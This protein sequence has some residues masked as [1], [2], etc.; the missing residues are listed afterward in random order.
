[1]NMDYT[2]CQALQ[3]INVG[4]SGTVIEYY[5][6]NCQHSKKFRIRVDK[7]SYLSIP[8]HIKLVPGIGLLH[9]TEHKPECVPRYAPTFIQGAGLVA[10]EIIELLWS[11]LNGCASSMRTATKANRAET[12]DDHMNDSNWSKM[13]NVPETIC[14]AY[15]RAATGLPGYQAELEE[16]TAIAGPENV[17]RWGRE[18]A[19][20]QAG[21]DKNI[22]G[23]DVYLA[24]AQKGVYGV[25]LHPPVYSHHLSSHPIRD[26][27]KSTS[28]GAVK[29]RE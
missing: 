3:H 4:E 2:V 26:S 11:G 19:K 7:S 25:M 21:R 13:L 15:Q 18:A 28:R 5:D 12:L 9:V 27:Y 23:M 20:A 16:R 24:T 14:K 10:G 17:R 22:D 29:W 8:A 1:M 6:V